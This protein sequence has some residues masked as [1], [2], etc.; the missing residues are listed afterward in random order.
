VPRAAREQQ[1][2]EVAARVFSHRGFHAA[3]M[4][5]IARECGLTKPMLYAYFRSKEGLYLATVDRAG[6]YLVAQVEELLDEP[7][8]LARLRRGSEILLR[9]IDR[10]RHGWTVLFAEGLG[11]GPVARH[12]GLYRAQIVRTAAITLAGSAEAGA[13]ARAEPYA[14]GMLGAGEALARWWLNQPAMPLDRVLVLARSLVESIYRAWT[15]EA[16]QP[17]LRIG[18]RGRLAPS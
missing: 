7:D 5:E 14:V 4:D 3:S 15:A 13:V 11:D 6:H 1:M 17:A 2:L 10:D 16:S 8:P 12:V 18:K 9:F